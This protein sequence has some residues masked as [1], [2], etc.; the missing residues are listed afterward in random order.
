MQQTASV[1]LNII[2]H[3]ITVIHVTY[4]KMVNAVLSLDYEQPKDFH[5]MSFVDFD[6]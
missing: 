2:P 4:F 6:F 3:D 1:R 5:E